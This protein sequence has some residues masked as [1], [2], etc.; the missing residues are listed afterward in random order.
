MKN[1]AN[2]IDVKLLSTSSIYFHIAHY[3]PRFA[4][5]LVTI[6][7]GIL[8]VY[9]FLSG[10]VF[11]SHTALELIT[12]AHSSISTLKALCFHWVLLSLTDIIFFFPFCV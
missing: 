10:S 11:Y 3:L 8:P 6:S 2:G 1:V 4:G 9:I 5:A 7:A 12:A